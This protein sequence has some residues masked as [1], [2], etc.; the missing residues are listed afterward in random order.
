MWELVLVSRDSE[1]SKEIGGVMD[2]TGLGTDL[3]LETE[4]GVTLGLG[5][6]F[7]GPDG[8]S[9]QHIYK[10][11]SEMQR[12]RGVLVTAMTSYQEDESMSLGEYRYGPQY[13]EIREHNRLM[14]GNPYQHYFETGDYSHEYQS[15][16]QDDLSHAEIFNQNIASLERRIEMLETRGHMK[17][18]IW[19]MVTRVPQ[20]TLIIHTCTKPNTLGIGICMRYVNDL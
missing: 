8:I 9:W 11:Q 2:V 16:H 7:L 6:C 3:N 18:I 5:T 12:G 20:N 1:K 10:Y 15:Y 17:I 13:Q 19:F 4:V 14:H